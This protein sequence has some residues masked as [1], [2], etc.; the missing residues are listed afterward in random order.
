M[1]LIWDRGVREHRNGGGRGLC[2]PGRRWLQ[3]HATPG[4]H[5]PFMTWNSL[6]SDSSRL[7]IEADARPVLEGEAEKLSLC[8]IP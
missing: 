3:S 4:Y 1:P 6:Y 7:I 8:S 5:K 2:S